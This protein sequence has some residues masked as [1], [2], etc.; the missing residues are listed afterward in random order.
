MIV[1]RSLNNI[2]ESIFKRTASQTLAQVALQAPPEQPS[3]P[4]TYTNG[5]HRPPIAGAVGTSDTNTIASSPRPQNY[6]IPPNGA[7]YSYNNGTPS[8]VTQQIASNISQQPY[9]TTQDPSM[10]PSHATSLQQT[11]P[12]AALLHTGTPYAYAN[13]QIA[14]TNQSHQPIYANDIPLA[15][16]HQW[17]RT[18]IAN[19]QPG[20]QGEYLD[21]VRTLGGRENS[22]SYQGGQGGPIDGLDDVTVMQTLG[23]TNWP[24]MQFVPTNNAFGSHQYGGQQ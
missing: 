10:T 22:A 2:S 14:A 19:K 17:T 15:E 5:T 16:W 6:T 1:E 7:G 3:A 20:T 11:G 8:S 18:T 24:L 23:S 4:T 21:S 13:A 9:N 12:T